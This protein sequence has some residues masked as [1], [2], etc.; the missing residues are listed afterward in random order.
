MNPVDL[1]V[2]FTKKKPEALALPKRAVIVFDAGDLRRLLSKKKHRP[3]DAWARFRWI[4]RI[5]ES[6]TVI[7][8]SYFG[9]P[10]VAAVVE[11]LSSFGVREI[12][13]WGYCGGIEKDIGLGDTIVAKGAIREDGVSYH[14]TEDEDAF[15]YANWLDEWQEK[16]KR[17][18]FREGL[19]WSCDAL[20]RETQGKIT[21][22][23]AQ[24]VS[25]V[26][27]EVASFYTVCTHRKVKGIAFLVVSDL[28][29]EMKW[30]PGFHTKP[31]GAGVK[32]LHEFMMEEVVR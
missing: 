26:E 6:D 29:R 16:A 25:A 13:L 9:G 32:K 18:G 19:I 12:V 2:T 11:E 5:E 20:Y 17:W 14:Y 30:T 15:V 24:G 22:Y 3:I 1:V 23:R 8:K 7:T 31:F 27:M 21:E 10:N 4:Y 28:F